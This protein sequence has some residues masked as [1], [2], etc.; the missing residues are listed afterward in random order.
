[1]ADIGLLNL[2]EEELNSKS[3]FRDEGVFSPNYLPEVLPHREEELK[4]LASYF[5]TV[6]NHPEFST[7]VFISGYSR[8]IGKTTLSKVFGKALEETA[9]KNHKNLRYIHMNCRNQNRAHL[10]LTQILGSLIPYFPIRGFSVPE[11]LRML[12]DSLT[13]KKLTL[14]LAL[15]EIEALLERREGY[16][17]IYSLLNLNNDSNKGYGVSVIAISNT[18]RVADQLEQVSSRFN[19]NKIELSPYLSKELETILWNRLTLG[20]GE[21]K[22]EKGLISEIA[23]FVADTGSAREAIDLLWMVAKRADLNKANIITTA[24]LELFILQKDTIKN[25]SSIESLI[26]SRS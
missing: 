13:K 22:A 18:P 16:E 9:R 1:M 2:I 3:L 26:T 4:L 12:R 23:I 6:F 7:A 20:I 11:L 14:V 19:Q 8:G 15:D 25:L 24:D 5:R 17:L 21:E 10:I